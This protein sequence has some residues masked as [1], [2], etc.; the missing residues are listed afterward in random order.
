MASGFSRRFGKENKLLVPFRGKPLVRYTL[1]LVMALNN[2]GAPDPDADRFGQV[3]FVA[4]DPAVIALAEAFRTE[5]RNSAGPSLGI[6]R[7]A[8]P[9]RGQRESIRLGV[10]ASEAVYYLFF[11]CDQPLLDGGTVR[12]LLAARREGCIVQP[13]FRGKPGNPVLFSAAFREELLSLGPGEHPR[14]IKNRHPEAL[15]TLELAGGEALFD[16]DDPETLKHL[17][18]GFSGCG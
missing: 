12:R 8:A 5:T 16:I 1:D 17:E 9:G 15:V 11:P 4:A 14:D 6:I 7:N 3:F 18:K 13:A 10:S 2:A